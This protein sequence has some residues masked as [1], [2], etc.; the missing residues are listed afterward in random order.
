MFGQVRHH[1]GGTDRIMAGTSESV[2]ASATLS[3]KLHGDRRVVSMIMHKGSYLMLWCLNDDDSVV[4]LV[5]LS[6]RGMLTCDSYHQIL[7]LHWCRINSQQQQLHSH[8]GIHCQEEQC[9]KNGTWAPKHDQ[10]ANMIF[11]MAKPVLMAHGQLGCCMQTSGT[12]L[13]PISKCS[14]CHIPWW[15]RVN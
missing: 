10:N 14:Q 1:T 12:T 2:P 3:C 11:T 5:S 15:I 8:C 4:M 9:S 13:F 7:M 6:W